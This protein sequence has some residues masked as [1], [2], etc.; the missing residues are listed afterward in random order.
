MGIIL[1]LGR[2]AGGEIRLS[3]SPSLALVT[4]V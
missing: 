3:P 1:L 4:A 2:P